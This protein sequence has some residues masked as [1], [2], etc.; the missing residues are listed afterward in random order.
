MYDLTQKHWIWV[1]PLAAKKYVISSL[2]TIS[3][4]YQEP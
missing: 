2:A 4:F 3:G 1:S